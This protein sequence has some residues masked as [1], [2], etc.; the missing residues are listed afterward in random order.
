MK[1]AGSSERLATTYETAWRHIEDD[2][3]LKSRSSFKSLTENGQLKY[4]SYS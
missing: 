4:V 3:I 2:C 1:A